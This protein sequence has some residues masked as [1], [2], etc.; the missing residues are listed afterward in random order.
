[1][2]KNGRP[3]LDPYIFLTL[4][5]YVCTVRGN[6]QGDTNYAHLVRTIYAVGQTFILNYVIPYM[7]RHK[8]KLYL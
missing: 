7:K 5:V 3:I 6:I 2:F 4:H 8:I 1:M